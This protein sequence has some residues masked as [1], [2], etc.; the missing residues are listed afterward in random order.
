MTSTRVNST[1]AL[2]FLCAT[3]LPARVPAESWVASWAAAQMIPEPNNALPADNLSGATL[4]QIVHLSTGGSTLRLRV[5]NAFGTAPL[6]LIAV[7]VAHPQS[8]ASGRIDPNSDLAVTFGERADVLIPAGAEYSSDPVKY[9]VAPLS[10]LAI[11]MQID[12]SPEQQTGHP[13]SRATSYLAAGA[14]VSALEL[15]AAQPIEHW[16]FLSGVDVGVKS[17]AAAVVAL[18]D[19]ITDG[20]GATTDGNDRWPDVLAARLQHNAATRQIS[21][22][23]AGIGGNRLLA[24][25]AGPNALARFDRDVLARAGVRYLIVLEGINDIGTLTRTKAASEAQHDELVRQL[26]EAYRQITLRARAHGIRVIGATIL[27]FTGSDFYHPGP[28]NEADRK[29]VNAWIRAPGHF[30]A[31]IDFDQVAADPAH[32]DHLRADYDIGDHLHPSP[33]GYRAMADAI[34]LELFRK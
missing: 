26:I 20:H 18:G 8:A 22:L 31:V 10:D 3:A 1:F 30:D 34:P 29:S 12:G 7:H 21:V 23:N 17:D 6:H 13:G 9:A 27:P 15:P 5:S 4:R 19:S 25:G 28:A 11:T 24:D 33:A 2:L 32:P 16:Y 14:S